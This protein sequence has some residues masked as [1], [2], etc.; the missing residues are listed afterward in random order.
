MKKPDLV[1]R[2][3]EH[4]INLDWYMVF[5]AFLI[6]A[7]LGWAFETS[8]VW[9]DTGQFTN[10]GYL[11]A[12]EPLGTYFPFL[13]GSSAVAGLPAVFGLPIIEIYGFGGVIMLAAFRHQ[14]NHPVRVFLYGS[15][16]LTLFELIS[17][18]FCSYVLQHEYWNYSSDL[19]NF[20]GRICLRSAIAWGLLS[21]VTVGVLDPFI[22]KLY[23]HE[24]RRKY[25][26]VIVTLIM[27]YAVVCGLLKYWLDPGLFPA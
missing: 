12:V 24:R 23:D 1:Q 11:M 6:C 5:F 26:K 13:A 9:R 18:Y 20:Q 4:R 14:R 17:S 10:R 2:L 8:V 16:L 21:V 15:V 22:E 3:R 25:F 7:F 19:L 27:V